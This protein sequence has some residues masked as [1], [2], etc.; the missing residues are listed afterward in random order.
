MI[1]LRTGPPET[2]L[3]GGRIH[4]TVQ[5]TADASAIAIAGGRVVAVGSD[6]EIDAIADDRTTVIELGGRAVTPAFVDSHTHF[7]RAALV[8]QLYLDFDVL[9]PRDHD[10]LLGQ[11][12][13]RHAALPA[14]TWLQ[15]DSLRPSA[16]AEGVLPDRRAL[17]RV[18]GDRPVVLRGI[19]KHVVLANSAALAAAGIDATTPDPPG[20]RIERDED[21]QPTGVLHERAKLRLDSSAVDTVIPSPSREARLDAIRAAIADVHRLGITTI[22]EMIRLPEEADDLASLHALGELPLRVRLSYRV[23]ETP[24]TLEHLAALGIRRGFGDAWFGVLGIKVSVDGWCIFGNAAVE[25]PYVGMAGD[26]GLMRIEPAELRTLVVAANARGLGVALHAVGPRAVDAALDAFEAAG[27]AT[28]GP[29]RL[30]HGHLDMDERRLARM[31]ELEVAWSVQPAL[32][33]AYRA[34][35]EAILEPARVDAIMPLAAGAALGIPI[36]LNSDVPSGPQAPFAAIRA[37]VT[38]DA[39]GRR[40]G[41]D[42]GISLVDAW[43]GWTTIPHA[44]AGERAL[45]A[46]LPGATADLIVLSADPFDRPADTLTDLAVDATM[47]DGRF[48]HGGPRDD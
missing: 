27:P 10:Q 17:D 21:G 45:G 38:R 46:L 4:A 14:G 28:A 3:R 13:T 23:F 6:D 7:H 43:R 32:L 22:H 34:D 40:I 29:Y 47:L 48:V 1:G 26:R 33:P 8:R 20:G 35:W 44:V 36:L 16:L 12:A 42:Q 37:A 11:V 24:I 18:C 25:E 5:G 41:A 15:G 9:A 30:E 2:I 31:R 19:G 39:G